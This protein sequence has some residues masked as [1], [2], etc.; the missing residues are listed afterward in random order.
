MSSDY[1][2]EMFSD[3]T[4]ELDY[5]I[6][7]I[8]PS[9]S[10]SINP[11]GRLGSN[12]HE[13]S[14]FKTKT[15]VFDPEK[16]GEYEIN[17]NGQTLQVNVIDSSGFAEPI[18]DPILWYPMDEGDGDILK[19]NI[20]KIGD[21]TIAGQSG[22]VT[23]E[24]MSGSG[25]KTKES[26][27]SSNAIELPDENGQYPANNFTIALTVELFNDQNRINLVDINSSGSSI[28]N[29]DSGIYLGANVSDDKI[30]VAL[31]ADYRASYTRSSGLNIN[32]KYRILVVRDGENVEVFVNGSSIG[33]KSLYSGSISYSAGAYEDNSVHIGSTARS[34]SENYT[35]EVIYDDFILYDKN[36]SSAQND[37]E[38]QP[39]S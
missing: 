6:E 19:D 24:F 13:L 34:G 39:W 36:M 21:A 16:A 7:N 17:I 38:R 29:R 14:G 1:D 35:R 23:G 37:Y 9:D 32:Q 33:S 4:L 11:K 8:N 28:E 31:E 27:D 18:G 15:A 22:W 3:D 12:S 2:V 20:G 5:I 25:V 30:E 10:L 26:S